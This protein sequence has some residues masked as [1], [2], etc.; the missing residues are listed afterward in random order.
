MVPSTRTDDIEMNPGTI[1]PY[2]PMKKELEKIHQTKL[3][4]SKCQQLSRTSSFPETIH[5]R[6]WLQ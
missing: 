5:S 1:L 6:H 4:T 3:S 2:A